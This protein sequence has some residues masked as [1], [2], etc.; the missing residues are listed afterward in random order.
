MHSVFFRVTP[1]I[2]SAEGLSEGLPSSPAPEIWDAMFSMVNISISYG[3]EWNRDFDS[4]H[5]AHSPTIAVHFR[6]GIAG[7]LS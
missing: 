6:G 2:K 5:M 7:R 4:C 3:I 1:T